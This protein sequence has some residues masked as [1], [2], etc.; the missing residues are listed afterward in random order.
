MVWK[1]VELDKVTEFFFFNVMEVFS[2][3][4]SHLAFA[5]TSLRSLLPHKITTLHFEQQ[6]NIQFSSTCVC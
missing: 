6:L 2:T 1:E 5:Q 3:T 4:G